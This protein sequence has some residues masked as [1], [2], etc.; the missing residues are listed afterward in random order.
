MF[1]G[2]DDFDHIDLFFRRTRGAGR[3]SAQ[4]CTPCGALQRPQSL[5]RSSVVAGVV[6]LPSSVLLLKYLRSSGSW[7]RDC[8]SLVYDCPHSWQSLWDDDM[9]PTVGL[10]NFSLIDPAE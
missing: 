3:D 10:F 4:D 2:A 5:S 7:G 8:A 9:D 1:S 6:V